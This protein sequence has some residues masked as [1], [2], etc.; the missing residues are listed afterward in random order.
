M[1]DELNNK[2]AEFKGVIDILPVNTKYNRKRKIDYI[3]EE[4]EQS[5]KNLELI[6]KEIEKRLFPLKQLQVNEQISLIESELEKCNIANEWN[7]YNTPYEKM[8]LDYYL[9]QLHRYYKDDLTGVNECIKRIVE[10]FKKVE[11]NLTKDDFDFSNDAKEY[12][13]KILNNSSEDEL[14][15][16]FEKIYWKNSDII[17]IIEINLKSIY[18]KYEKKIIKYYTDRHQEF[19]KKH[20]DD[21]LFQMRVKLNKD[22]NTLKDTDPYL[23]FQ[24]FINHEYSTKEL[25]DTEIEKKKS[26]YFNQDNY[27]MDNLVKLLSSLDE[28]NML[29]KY[30]YLLT[31][32]R[33]RLEKKEEFK[34]VLTNTLKDITKE[35]AKLKKMVVKQ[36]AKPILFFKKKNDE[37]WLFD[38]NSTL[39]EI[40]KKYDT[41]DDIRFNELVFTKLS[42]DSTVFDVLKFIAS[43]YLYFVER[44]KELEDGSDINIIN[45]KFNVLK[46]ELF[47]K[48]GYMLINNL[49]LLDEKQIKQIIADKYNLDNITLSMELLQVD[50][51]E[52]TIGDI[53]T[54]INYE[55][56]K[57]SGINTNDVDL[58]IE[59]SKLVKE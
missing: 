22:L 19:L 27:S 35:E 12:M 17:K 33:T 25:S 30:N 32:M 50:N 24:K 53:K 31:D 9:Y 49:A 45:D 26:T 5:K 47:S 55:N 21:E 1:I 28:Y 58:Y 29:L 4:E 48:D 6:K 14:K 16:Y 10:S 15:E 54:L 57:I 18:L 2:Y 42:K 34:N 13:E 3:T 7:E 23:V 11:I 40:S 46:E 8:H 36:N 51:L 44:T 39:D 59:Y 41:L 38:Y 52:R 20:K 37:K 56:L 43:N